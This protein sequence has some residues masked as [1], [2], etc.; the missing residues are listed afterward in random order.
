MDQWDPSDENLKERTPQ[1]RVPRVI[2][3]AKSPI[4]GLFLYLVRLI[5]CII[6]LCASAILCIENTIIRI[7]VSRVRCGEECMTDILTVVAASLGKGILSWD[8]WHW[9]FSW[10]QTKYIGS[11]YTER[12][13]VYF[14]L[15]NLKALY[16]HG[17]AL[18]EL[19]PPRVAI[20]IW[21]SCSG[22][23][24]DFK[25]PYLNY[26]SSLTPLERSLFRFYT[27]NCS[28]KFKWSLHRTLWA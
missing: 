2:W 8:L 22:S 26:R 15:F 13:R 19:Y 24:I 21:L 7:T 18:A 16:F 6:F 17:S 20:C 9:T 1:G 28:D 3:V 25:C 11:R 4:L 12:S 27:T 5:T 14:N 10:S 23:A